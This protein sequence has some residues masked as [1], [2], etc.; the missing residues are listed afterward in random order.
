[1]GT[2]VLEAKFFQKLAGIYYN[3]LF[4]VFLD[5]RKAYDSL[6]RGRF[7]DILKGYKLG[8]NTAQL[9]GNYWKNQKI[10]P[11]VEQFLWRPLNMGCGI[12]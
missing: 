9:L 12:T 11:K 4:Q 7:M 2:T 8:L 6:D 3:M 10:L 5:T 1:M